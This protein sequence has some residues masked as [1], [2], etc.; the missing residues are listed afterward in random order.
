MRQS[1]YGHSPQQ[2]SLPQQRVIPDVT[3]SV[4]RLEVLCHAGSTCT[5]IPRGQGLS[6]GQ[7]ITKQQP[8]DVTRTIIPRGQGLLHGK[9]IR[10]QQSLDVT[11]TII[12]WG[13]GLLHGQPIRRQQSL[14]VTL[15]RAKKFCASN[16][17][18]Q[19]IPYLRQ[20][21]FS[22]ALYFS[23]YQLGEFLVMSR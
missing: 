16:Y 15:L 21:F 4:G 7:P 19:V 9:P 22:V 12:P 17:H 2:L 3:N 11:R 18:E 8:L 6:S 20:F 14:D 5:I 10:R 1:C 23:V 13:Q